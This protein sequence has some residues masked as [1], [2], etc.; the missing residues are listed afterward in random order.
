MAYRLGYYVG[1]CSW[2]FVVHGGI[3][4]SVMA[5]RVWDPRRAYYKLNV[6]EGKGGETRCDSTRAASRGA[7]MLVV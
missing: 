1:T 3:A 6:H 4:E 5:Y 2:T 7:V